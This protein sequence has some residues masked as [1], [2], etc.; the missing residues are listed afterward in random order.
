MRGDEDRDLD[1]TMS[2]FAA[3]KAEVQPAAPGRETQVIVLPDPPPPVIKPSTTWAQ[4]HVWH[5]PLSQLVD[6]LEKQAY[7][8]H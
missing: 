4:E 8:P 2:F 3:V 6:E 5:K 7:A 1:D